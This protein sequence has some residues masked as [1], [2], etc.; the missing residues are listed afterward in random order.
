MNPSQIVQFARDLAGCRTDEIGDSLLFSYMNIE[1]RKL[2]QDIADTDKN[3]KLREWKTDLVAGVSLY[4]LEPVNNVSP[5]N[6]GQIKIE[7]LFIEYDDGQ[8]YPYRA[9][10]RDWDNLEASPEWYG[11]TQNKYDPFYIIT[12]NSIRIFPTPDNS[13]AQ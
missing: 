7:S 3:Y 4:E 12:D 5:Q 9:T 11:E 8:E 10:Y 6:T 13:V 1:Y 2:W